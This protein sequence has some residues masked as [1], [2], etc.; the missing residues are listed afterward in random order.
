[1]NDSINEL[2]AHK[3]AKILSQVMKNVL[4]REMTLQDGAET[5]LRHIGRERKVLFYKSVEIG[6]M[7][8]EFIYHKIVIR[9]VARDVRDISKELVDKEYKDFKHPGLRR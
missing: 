6:T 2:I 4:G 8:I 9:F 3:E 1:M 7:K 5:E